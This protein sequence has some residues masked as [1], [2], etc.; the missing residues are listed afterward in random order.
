M[1]VFWNRT[2]FHKSNICEKLIIS[3]L[4]LERGEIE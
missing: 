3:T 1:L 2:N 4:N